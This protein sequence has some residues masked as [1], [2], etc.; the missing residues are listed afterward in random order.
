MLRRQISDISQLGIKLLLRG[1]EGT[2]SHFGAM[3]DNSQSANYH[4]SHIANFVLLRPE[5][6]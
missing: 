3:V 6:T 4:S 1:E 2:T 5:C